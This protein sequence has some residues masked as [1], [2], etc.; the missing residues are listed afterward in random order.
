MG[1]WRGG[2]ITFSPKYELYKRENLSGECEQAGQQRI[3]RIW[4]KFHISLWGGSSLSCAVFLIARDK[5]N[6]NRVVVRLF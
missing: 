2:Y 3:T 4:F 1:G 5:R 6:L